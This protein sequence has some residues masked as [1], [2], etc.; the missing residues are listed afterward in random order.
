MRHQMDVVFEK[1]IPV[2]IIIGTSEIETNTV[3]IKNIS[4]KT[5]IN[6]PYKLMVE[7]VKLH[8]GY[9]FKSVS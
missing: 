7:T 3:T 5:Q 6:V 4:T 2:M 9:G 8:L 1:K